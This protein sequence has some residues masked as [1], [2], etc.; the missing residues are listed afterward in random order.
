MLLRLAG[1]GI[2]GAPAGAA[3]AAASEGKKPDAPP[4]AP[5]K[6]VNYFAIQ[7]IWAYVDKASLLP[8][9]PLN[10]M[11]A[12][13]PGEPERQVH[14]EVFRIGAGGA[15]SLV[16]TSE[17][18]SVAHRP[19]TASGAAIGPNWSPA[20]ADID[21]GAWRPGCY[22]LD[23]VEQV[24]ATRDVRAAQWIVRNPARSGAVLARLG[25]NTY[26]AYN[27]WG[28]HSLYPSDDDLARGVMVTFDRPTP[29]SFFEYDAYL[30][31]WLE[32]L[33]PS[34][35]GAVDYASNFDVHRDPTLMDGYKLVITGAHDEYW[36]GEE[37]DAFER[38]IFRRG[39]NTAFFG[40]NTAYC[41][42]RYA[43]VNREPGGAEQ[44][45]QLVCYRDGSDPILR[46]AGKAD[47]AL[48]AT[49][50]FRDD[51]R[52]PE[53]MLTG[54]AY[55]SW[56]DPGG[57]L[58]YP[59]LVARTDLPFFDGV[60]W[61]VGD[62]IGDVVGY[63]WDNRDPD[64]DGKRL[65]DKARSHNAEIPAADIQVLFHGAPVDVDGDTGRAEALYWRSAAGAQVFSAGSIR[66]AW[67][68]GKEGFAQPAFQ[69]F[70]ENLVRALSR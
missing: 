66:W 7:R 54:G 50:L 49:R 4:P 68:L 37:F 44:G 5:E 48:M 30:V 36:S 61:R 23:V 26:Q 64:G 3:A 21:T 19:A 58:R 57:P 2:I 63:E 8:G 40:G 27:D 18:V 29:P 56:F 28:G 35:G 41:Q 20:I 67:G 62:A 38:R 15:Q 17:P 16:W 9:E 6:W 70:N 32:A 14:V 11:M 24:T 43:D 47:R 55:Q 59:Y 39:G 22:S 69:R 13:G 31:G 65:W 12:G 53:T 46:R 10:V 1:A 52:R 51:A 60:G 25:T 33:A 45:R 42:I 34:L